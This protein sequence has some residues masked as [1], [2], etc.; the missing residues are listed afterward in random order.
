MSIAIGV[1]GHGIIWMLEAGWVFGGNLEDTIY[2]NVGLC[3]YS[4]R[5]PRSV[6]QQFR[7]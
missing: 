3:G 4:E 6:P 1:I 5:Q 2:L 7:Q